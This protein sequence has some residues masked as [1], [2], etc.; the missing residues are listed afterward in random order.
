MYMIILAA[1]Q[2]QVRLLIC[3]RPEKVYGQQILMADMEVIGELHSHH[4]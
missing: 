3:V 1:G 2:Q 4:R